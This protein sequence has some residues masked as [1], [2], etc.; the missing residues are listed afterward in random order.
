M[1][2]ILPKTFSPLYVLRL[3]ILFVLYFVTAKIGL[4]LDAVSGFATPVWAPTGISLA[5][6]LLFGY[7]LWPAIFLA[8]FLVNLSTGATPLAAFGIGLGNTLEAVVAAKLI[9]RLVKVD[10][11]GK[12]VKG[13]F[14]LIFFGAVVGPLVSAT[15]GVFSLRINGIISDNAALIPTFTAWWIGDALGSLV[16]TP[17]LIVLLQKTKSKQNLQLEKINFNRL[18][19]TVALYSLFIFLYFIVFWD[20][21]GFKDHSGHIL[22]L[23]F[24]PLIWSSIRYKPRVTLLNTVAVSILTIYAT[25]QGVGPFITPML[26]QSLIFL[27]LFIGVSTLISLT[28][29]AAI[30][31][32]LEVNKAL[33]FRVI[34]Y[35]KQN[36][37]LEEVKKDLISTAEQ[38]LTE[39]IN[40]DHERYKLE[41]ILTSIGDAVFV[42]DT[43]YHIILMNSVAEK[44]SGY[45]F[46]DV[47]NNLYSTVFH[48]ISE[49]SPDS[50]YPPII[51]NVIKSGVNSEMRNHTILIK[52]NGEKIPVADSVA[53]VK[54]ETGKILGCVVVV[55]NISREREL[56]QA[57]DNFLSI[58]AHQLRTPL[59]GIKW[60][61]EKLTDMGIQKTQESVIAEISDNN[62]RMIALVNDLLEAARIDQKSIKDSPQN[63]DVNQ[64]IGNIIEE[65]K[66]E[67]KKDGIG[68]H[69]AYN[70][71]EI[72][73]IYIDPNRFRGALEN[74]ISNSIKY[75]VPK[76][77]V[78]IAVESKDQYIVVTVTDTGI[79]IPEEAQK[80]VF[81]KFFRANNALR[82]RTKGTGLGLFVAKSYIEEWGGTLTFES[83]EG[84][85]TKFTISIPLLVKSDISN[86]I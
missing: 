47:K 44:L 36:K 30:A 28:L 54:D 4:S 81:T 11:I 64:T 52:K 76:G 37:I 8:A 82:T 70:S 20:Y 41:T 69:V 59:T 61:L 13:N 26:S 74:I 60:H 15:I 33:Q 79:G 63:T 21:L 12:S 25:V 53:A 7:D 19:E 34:E 55:R 68:I 57:K 14:I 62:E 48:F 50:P 72:P 43:K 27:Q 3:L 46:E 56:E 5:F 32:R 42:V 77:R 23:L 39:K 17:A 49:K 38:V 86:K 73:N 10:E 85:G 29:S 1:Q 67:A 84:K 51:E 35:E 45:R 65:L 75:N 58:A 71:P 80:K 83:S 16:V 22:Y 24:L 66:P 9:L 31:E 78:D 40:V 2:N 6:I 18:L